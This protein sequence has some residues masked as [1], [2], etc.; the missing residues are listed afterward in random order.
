MNKFPNLP[1]PQEEVSVLVVGQP[2]QD[3]RRIQQI[4]T[5]PNWSIGNAASL[6]AGL[7]RLRGGNVQII[8]C[9]RDLID[10]DWRT[11]LSALETLDRPPLLIV[12]SAQADEHLWAEVL[13]LGGYDV[14][15]KPYDGL[16]VHR[17]LG[18]AWHHWQRRWQH[19]AKSASAAGTIGRW[20]V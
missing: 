16:E 3:R 2:D 7:R 17:V 10:G 6:A 5:N 12:T 14:L 11:L 8:L 9:E 18:L 15:P 4:L 1:Q 19:E 20:A 13:N